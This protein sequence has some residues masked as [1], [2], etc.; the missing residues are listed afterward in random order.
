M[1]SSDSSE[2]TPEEDYSPRVRA[3]RRSSSEHCAVC[4]SG[5]RSGVNVTAIRSKCHWYFFTHTGK[6][7]LS[8]LSQS[9]LSAPP[10]PKK[11][12]SPHHNPPGNIL[13]QILTDIPEI[14]IRPVC[15]PKR[16]VRNFRYVVELKIRNFR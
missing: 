14:D 5:V 8:L 2:A 7:S 10:P 12:K 11:Q 3:A 13:G 15:M 16:Y 6:R 1:E 9:S 4:V